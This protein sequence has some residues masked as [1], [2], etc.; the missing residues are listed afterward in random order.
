VLPELIR[1]FDAGERVSFGA[2]WIDRS[3][4]GSGSEASGSESAFVAWPD[5]T[6]IHIDARTSVSIAAAGRRRHLHIDLGNAPNGFFAH[7][8]IEHAAARAGIGVT[9]DGETRMPLRASAGL[10]GV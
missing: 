3:G 4:I 2:A 7:Y 1:G 6:A 8:L 9:Y 5:I 10:A